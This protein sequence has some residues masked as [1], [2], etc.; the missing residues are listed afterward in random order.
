MLQNIESTKFELED[1]IENQMRSQLEVP[2]FIG[3]ENAPFS[4][5]GE[6]A[7]QTYSEFNSKFEDLYS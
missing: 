4:T 1:K 6:W 5:I 7:S 3:G 2:G